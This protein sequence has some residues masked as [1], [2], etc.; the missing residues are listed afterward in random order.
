MNSFIIIISLICFLSVIGFAF[1]LLKPY[2]TKSET[3]SKSSN[4]YRNPFDPGD[5]LYDSTE[6]WLE[7]SKTLDKT[8]YEFETMM[9]R[10]MKE[11]SIENGYN[12]TFSKEPSFEKWLEKQH[13]NTRVNS[14]K[15]SALIY[16][17]LKSSMNQM[18]H[19][20][21]EDQLKNVNHSG[22]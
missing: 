12:I 18:M 17:N 11:K 3:K 8:M 15:E 22:K 9:K 20:M 1:C 13:N 16:E 19:I 21:R 2:M 4:Y 6:S 7:S 14:P 10:S 5:K